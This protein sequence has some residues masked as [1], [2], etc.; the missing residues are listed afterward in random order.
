V[1]LLC[2]ASFF[3]L[4]LSQFATAQSADFEVAQNGHAVG[5]ASFTLT[6]ESQG[7]DTASIV[8]VAMQ[9]LDYALS[10][11]EQLT[12]GRQLIQVQLNATVNGSAVTVAARPDAGQ[13]LLDISA[14]GRKTSTRLTAHAGAVF[15]PDFDPGALEA[16]L[17]SAAAQNNRDVWAI[18]PKGPGA[19]VQVELA[20]FADMTGTMDGKPLVVHHLVATIDGAKTELFSGPQNQLLQ[21]ELPQQ[22]FALVRQGFVL[23]PSAKAPPATPS[24]VTQGMPEP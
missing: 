10:S 3:G 19:E 14:G 7:S 21:A 20:T 8:R 4:I 12:A 9:G 22:G 16:L 17:A 6:A 18:L 13:L 15:L 11:S 5:K 1:R 23:Q 2:L 24:A